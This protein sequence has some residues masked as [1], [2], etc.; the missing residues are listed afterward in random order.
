MLASLEKIIARQQKVQ[1]DTTAISAKGAKAAKGSA[2]NATQLAAQ[3][4]ELKANTATLVL[5][6]NSPD[7]QPA[8]DPFEQRR[9]PDGELT[10]RLGEIQ[11]GGGA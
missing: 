8:A 9:E 3:E 5:A 10:D 6:L 7:T 4:A 11:R 2:A 1:T